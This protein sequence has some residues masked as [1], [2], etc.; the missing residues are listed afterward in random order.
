MFTVTETPLK[1]LKIIS[2]NHFTDERGMFHKYFSKDEYKE[3]GLDYDF[4]E[5]YYSINKKNVIRGM[6]FQIPP[7]DHAKLVYVTSGRIIDVCLDIRKNSRTYGKYF[8]I[9]LTADKAECIYIPKGFAHGFVSLE[10]NTCVHYLQTS[11]YSKE[12]DCGINYDSFGYDWGVENPIVSGRDLTHPSFKKFDSPFTGKKVVLTGATGL[13]GK[14]AVQPLKDAG[15]EVYC[16]TSKNC[17]LFD[18]GAVDRFFERVKPEYL[19]HFAWMTGGDYLTNPINYD[20][21]D[22]SMNMLKAFHKHG[23]KRAVYAGTCFEYAFK[24]E[25]LKETDPL[26]PKTLYAQCKVELCKKA[27]EYCER[28]NISF[29]WGR[30]FYVYGHNEKEGRLTQLIISK[31][32]NNEEVVINHGQLIRDYMYSKDIALAF[33]TILLSDYKDC[34][35]VCTGKGITIGDFALNFGKIIN[36]EKLISIRNEVTEQPISIVGDN[37]ILTDVIKFNLHPSFEKNILLIMYNE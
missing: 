7:A 25:P 8:S 1:G 35:N 37:S 16:L 20:Y 9:V 4:E 27:T 5:D 24:N 34:V 22:A 2:T 6:H 30:I 26:E 29:A 17:N 10:D 33:V 28:N 32:K 3:L 31:L 21:V 36:K 19:L 13:I 15:F 11:C 14:E 23:G 12:C 18:Y